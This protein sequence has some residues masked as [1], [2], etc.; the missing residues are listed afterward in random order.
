MSVT[1]QVAEVESPVGDFDDG[2]GGIAW[3]VVLARFPPP[4]SSWS[5][6]SCCPTILLLP[7]LP[8]LLSLLLLLLLLGVGAT[9]LPPLL[10][11]LLLLP[12]PARDFSA[13]VT[14]SSN[15]SS[16]VTFVA[17]SFSSARRRFRD[18]CMNI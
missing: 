13:G 4:T 10:L 6:L 7:L 14:I 18:Y 16:C 9:L 1:L 5:R 12:P 8:P 15:F 17:N 2:A 11:L 3:E